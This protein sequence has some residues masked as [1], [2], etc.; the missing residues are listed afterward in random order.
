MP[1]RKDRAITLDLPAIRSAED[2]ANAT[3]AVVVAVGEG[4]ITPSEAGEVVGLIETCRNRIAAERAIQI[5]F[6]SAGGES[7]D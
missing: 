7:S 6:V 4:R 5:S 1:P 3:R 2:A